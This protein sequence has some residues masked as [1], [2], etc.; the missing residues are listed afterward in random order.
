MDVQQIISQQ[1]PA[2]SPQALEASSTSFGASYEL[3]LDDLTYDQQIIPI[4]PGV[5]LNPMVYEQLSPIIDGLLL[6]KEDDASIQYMKQLIRQFR[7]LSKKDQKII[8][9]FLVREFDWS[10]HPTLMSV[11][12][13]QL[14]HY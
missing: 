13:S 11:I 1:V 6:H 2:V 8:L 10:F 12:S 14:R 3:A 5:E 9:N 7:Q 4:E